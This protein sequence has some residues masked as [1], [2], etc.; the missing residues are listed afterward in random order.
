[1]A[2]RGGDAGADILGTV[3]LRLLRPIGT[4]E[5]LAR[6]A[7]GV[8]IAGFQERF[9]E[10]RRGDVPDGEHRLV[11]DLANL[12]RIAALSAAL[13]L[14]RRMD[15]GVVHAGEDIDINAIRA[16]LDIR[17]DLAHIVDF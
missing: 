12:P 11:G 17:H 14:H 5:E 2:T 16:L 3:F 15:E 4:G 13:E 7:D 10:V 6:E 8:G 1:M 9:G